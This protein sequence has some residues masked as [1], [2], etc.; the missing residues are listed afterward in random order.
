MDSGSRP[1]KSAFNCR[2]D[3]LSLAGRALLSIPAAW[4]RRHKHKEEIMPKSKKKSVIVNKDINKKPKI[5]RKNTKSDKSNRLTPTKSHSTGKKPEK[6]DSKQ[7]K[8][9]TLL[10]RPEGATIEELISATGWQK[11]SV[12]GV[13]S[14][15]LKKK[16]GLPVTH[17]KETRGKIYRIAGSR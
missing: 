5:S 15:A 13:I 1:H 16:L 7:S 2:K 9:I 3:W 12:R 14:G 17:Y 4:C 8:I 6:Q 11:H 10:E